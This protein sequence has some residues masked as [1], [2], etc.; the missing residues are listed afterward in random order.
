MRSQNKFS[1]VVQGGFYKILFCLL[2]KNHH[3][4]LNSYQCYTPSY[5]I[6]SGRTVITDSN[7]DCNNNTLLSFSA[8]FLD[9]L[10]AFFL[11]AA[12]FLV[13]GFFLVAAF[14]GAYWFVYESEVGI[15]LLI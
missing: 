1:F 4:N 12:F 14:L 11:G 8:Y 13:A 3:L 9:F 10:V 2:F 15:R 5:N 7:E 6:Q